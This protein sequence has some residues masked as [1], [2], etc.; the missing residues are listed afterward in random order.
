MGSPLLFHR[1]HHQRMSN[2]VVL[3]ETAHRLHL[4]SLHPAVVST[5]AHCGSPCRFRNTRSKQQP[6]ARNSCTNLLQNHPRHSIAPS[7]HFHSICVGSDGLHCGPPAKSRT[8]SLNAAL[9]QSQHCVTREM[10]KPSGHVPNGH[11]DHQDR[12]TTIAT[13]GSRHAFIV[14]CA[15]I[16]PARLSGGADRDG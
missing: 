12:Q 4:K 10:G 13:E 9:H 8:R 3:S 16:I 2:A 1:H 7:E 11:A 5:T 6:H 15:A 14:V